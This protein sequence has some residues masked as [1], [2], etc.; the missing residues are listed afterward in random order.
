MEHTIAQQ[1]SFTALL[2]KFERGLCRA[3]KWKPDPLLYCCHADWSSAARYIKCRQ[4][5]KASL[6]AY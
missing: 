1:E 5:L 6:F 4:S 2:C 3:K